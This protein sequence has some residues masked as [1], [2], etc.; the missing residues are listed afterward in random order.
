MTISDPRLARELALREHQLTALRAA[1][2]IAAH[3]GKALRPED[4]PQLTDGDMLGSVTAAL[5]RAGLQ[6]RLLQRCTVKTAATL[7]TAY[8]ALIPRRDG[9]WIILITVMVQDG[10]QVDRKSVV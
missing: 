6:S 5:G 2:L 10:S 1:F 7:G 9:S 4:L 8:P 3:H